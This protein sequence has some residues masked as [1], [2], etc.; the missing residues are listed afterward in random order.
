ME[1]VPDSQD[2][3][4]GAA[5]EGESVADTSDWCSGWSRSPQNSWCE[6]EKSNLVHD[7]RGAGEQDEREQQEGW[8][9]A[10]DT[11]DC[12]SESRSIPWST[13]GGTGD[14]QPRREQSQ[15]GEGSG[16]GMAGWEG[17]GR[18]LHEWG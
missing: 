6:A 15:I 9:G 3:G 17:A 18:W 12:D 2:V 7:T 8:P 10:E 4:S 5:P 13:V 11:C 14:V 16:G 1:L